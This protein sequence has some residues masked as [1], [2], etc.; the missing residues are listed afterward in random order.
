MHVKGAF[1]VAGLVIPVA[2]H[3]QQLRS[4][5]R[6]TAEFQEP[7][8]RVATLRELS[9]GRVIVGDEHDATLQ[10]ID[11]RAGRGQRS[12]APAQAL[13]SISAWPASSSCLATPP[14][15]TIRETPAI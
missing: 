8:T 12:A 4:L 1:I 14:R 5:G 2:T 13:A 7:F 11:F 10:V 9:D 3:A 6:P 15:Y